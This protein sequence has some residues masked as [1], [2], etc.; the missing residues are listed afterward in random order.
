MPRKGSVT[1][2]HAGR[3]KKMPYSQGGNGKS[4]VGDVTELDT[5]FLECRDLRHAWKVM[6][7][8]R[9]DNSDRILRT[10][11]CTRCRTERVDVMKDTGEMT[12]RQYHYPDNYLLKGFTDRKVGLRV[13]HVREELIRRVMSA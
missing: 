12:T 7:W 6:A 13:A 9:I 4:E 8:E 5:T 3:R 2:I 1:V 11:R 10:A